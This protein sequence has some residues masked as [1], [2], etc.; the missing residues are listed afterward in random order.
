MQEFI[1]G[2]VS[3]DEPGPELL[4]FVGEDGTVSKLTTYPDG[5]ETRGTDGSGTLAA[6]LGRDP[7]PGW[8]TASG[9]SYNSTQGDP[10]VS[11]SQED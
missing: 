4:Y 11:D 9:R 3:F 10:G 5:T 2:I 8:Y 7:E 6:L 1:P